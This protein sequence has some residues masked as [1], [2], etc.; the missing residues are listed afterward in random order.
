MSAGAIS[1]QT[2]LAPTVRTSCHLPN[3]Y[4]PR[5]QHISPDGCRY[6]IAAAAPNFQL[7]IAIPA[8]WPMPPA[9][10]ALFTVGAQLQDGSESA[11]GP[12]L[13]NVTAPGCPRASCVS[14]ELAR[15]PVLHLRCWRCE[16]RGATAYVGMHVLPALRT[17]RIATLQQLRAVLQMLQR[18]FALRLFEKELSGAHHAIVL[19]LWDVCSTVL[20]A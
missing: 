18:G 2:P 10:A 1:G 6:P 19:L 17:C 13:D 7:P 11:V 9:A 14:V 15:N 3:G 5:W 4:S 16:G 12:M 8:P 20:W